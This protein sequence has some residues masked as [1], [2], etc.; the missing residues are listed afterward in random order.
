MTMTVF[1]LNGK[2]VR[3]HMRDGWMYRGPVLSENDTYLTIR[4][5]KSR[6][7]VLVRKEEISRIEVHA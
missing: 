1:D 7:D 5:L 4:D 2:V 6:H 3:I